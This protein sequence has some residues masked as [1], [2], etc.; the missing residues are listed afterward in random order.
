MYY[1]ALPVISLSFYF[2]NSQVRKQSLLTRN[3]AHFRPENHE[4]GLNHAK[5]SSPKLPQMI[6][7]Q[8]LRV[9]ADFCK[10]FAG[11]LGCG[12]SQRTGDRE[13]SILPK[14]GWRECSFTSTSFAKLND[15]MI[16]LTNAH[17]P[18]HSKVSNGT[19]AGSQINPADA[20]P[21]ERFEGLLNRTVRITCNFQY[22]PTPA[23]AKAG[24]A[25]GTT[26]G[27]EP[28]LSRPWRSLQPVRWPLQGNSRSYTL[29]PSVFSGV[30]ACCLPALNFD[31]ALRPQ[32]S[33]LLRACPLL[34]RAFKAAV[35]QP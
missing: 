20:K 3:T 33:L 29:Q 14:K 18:S 27:V 23:F 25:P 21:R 16:R 24:A 6:S 2:F 13:P 5:S 11:N 1:N 32:F 28:A 17:T 15:V 12:K 35:C 9:F 22:P 8:D 19:L 26:G 4:I 31:Q 10:C 7:V 34:L 30:Q